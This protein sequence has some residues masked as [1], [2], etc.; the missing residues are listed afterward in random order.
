MLSKLVIMQFKLLAQSLP[1]LFSN[2]V[3]PFAMY[4]LMPGFDSSAFPAFL[5]AYIVFTPQNGREGLYKLET[6]RIHFP[7]TSR[8]LVQGLFLFQ[9]AIVLVA[10]II[11][12]GF[13]AVVGQ[14]SG[15]VF[16]QLIIPKAMALSLLAAGISPCLALRLPSD[17]SQ[18]VS[19]LI[20]IAITLLMVLTKP[21]EGVFLP[22]LSL[23]ACLAIGLVGFLACYL[24]AMGRPKAVERR[25][26]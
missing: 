23:P 10:G 12:A 7:V 1:L 26:A 18:V 17:M 25:A 15:R 6:I 3:A 21:G 11:A 20:I 19:I 24:I 8:E 5:I 4:V 9:A 22:W 14:I 2:L 13:V 16:M